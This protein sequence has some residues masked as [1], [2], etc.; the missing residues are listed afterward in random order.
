[1][2]TS[3]N[4]LGGSVGL[5]TTAFKAGVMELTNQMKSIET[6]FR[7]SAAVMGDWSNTSTGLKDRM[8]SL[9]D[10]LKNQKQEL[11]ILNTE[12]VI[13]VASE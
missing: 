13:I 5:D 4:N 3:E 12:Y 9:T 7:A 10:K 1:M 11:G 6:S 8:S 2:S